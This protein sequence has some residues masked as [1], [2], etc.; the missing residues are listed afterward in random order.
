M[1][2]KIIPQDQSVKNPFLV[3]FVGLITSAFLIVAFWTKL[4]PEAPLYFSR[5]WG[6]AQLTSPLFLILPLAL[7]LA[8]LLANSLLSHRTSDNFLKKVLIWGAITASV[9]ASI[10]VARIVFLIT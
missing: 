5:P 6:E 2:P 3:G 9:L 7:S 10:T 8:F 4:P 1:Q